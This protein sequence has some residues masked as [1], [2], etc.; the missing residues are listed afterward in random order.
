MLAVRL[1]LLQRCMYKIMQV[2]EQKVTGAESTPQVDKRSV[3]VIRTTVE[4]YFN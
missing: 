4:Q 1:S 2:A 3:C